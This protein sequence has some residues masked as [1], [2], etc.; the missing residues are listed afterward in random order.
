MEREKEL[1]EEL[2][3][4]ISMLLQQMNAADPEQ[5]ERVKSIVK[6]NVSF[7]SRSALLAYLLLNSKMPK[8]EKDERKSEKKPLPAKEKSAEEKKPQQ[9][10]PADAKTIYIDVGKMKHL[11]PRDL[12]KRIQAE[13]GI[14]RDDIYA[15]RIHDKYSFV[16]M[17]EENCNKAIEKLTGLDFNGRTAKVAYSNK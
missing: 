5:L 17:S 10:I 4:K 3:A 8:A 9:P 12:S 16:T 2:S 14:T 7:F 6:K 11:Y 1:D 15:I 13:L